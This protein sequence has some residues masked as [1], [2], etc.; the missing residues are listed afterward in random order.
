[1][2]F[3]IK[4]YVFLKQCFRHQC[5]NIITVTIVLT[6]FLKYVFVIIKT[7]YFIEIEFLFFTL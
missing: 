6:L 7:N 1:M 3:I 4:L 2:F 5:Y